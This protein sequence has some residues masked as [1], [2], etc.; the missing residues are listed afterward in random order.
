MTYYNNMGSGQPGVA[1]GP[2]A[3]RRA[4]RGCLGGMIGHLVALGILAIPLFL[5]GIPAWQVRAGGV[6]TVGTATLTASCGESTDADGNPTPETFEV[7]IQFTDQNGQLHKVGSHWACNN[8]YN[9]GEQ[10]SLWYLPGDPS[11]FLTGGE[12]FWLYITSALWTVI[13]FMVLL[14]FFTLLRARLLGSRASTSY[15]M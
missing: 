10:V 4:A 3:R 8:F 15:S 14:G 13:T 6:S 1:F 2:V 11:R 9:D 7:T 5:I 12:A